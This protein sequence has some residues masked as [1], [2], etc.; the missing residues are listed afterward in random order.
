MLLIVFLHKDCCT[1]GR[2]TR[3]T[4]P[5][6][7]V[8]FNTSSSFGK[9]HFIVGYPHHKELSQ[10]ADSS[11]TTHSN[12]HSSSTLQRALFSPDDNVQ[13]SL[14][15]L[16]DQ[17]SKSIRIAVFLF[18]DIEIAKALIRAK[19]RDVQIEIVTDPSCLQDTFSKISFLNDH[20]IPI[21]VYDPTHYKTVMSNK[22][23]N[24]FALFER[25]LNNGSL[26]WIGSFN[27]TKSA[28]VNNQESV[29]VLDSPDIIKQF[30]AQFALLKER[31]NLFSSKNHHNGKQRTKHNW[32]G[33]A[34]DKRKK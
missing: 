25:N 10:K 13:K 31:S 2:R 16:I 23:H 20:D 26:V 3:I 28:D 12:L 1:R 21:F 4:S 11:D 19:M 15:N 30:Y 7:N 5:R 17:E 8:A 27:F 34:S 24:K 33:K 14:I 6:M 32:F 29:V 18:T 9:T 22:M